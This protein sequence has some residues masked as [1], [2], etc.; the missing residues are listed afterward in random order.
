MF[1]FFDPRAPG[2]GLDKA[3]IFR[4]ALLALVLVGLIVGSALVLHFVIPESKWSQAA[5]HC[6]IET[7]GCGC[8]EGPSIGPAPR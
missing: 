6:W 1:P 3:L 2:S 7:G 5:C 4:G 8:Q